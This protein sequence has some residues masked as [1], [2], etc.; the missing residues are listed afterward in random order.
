MLSVSSG[1]SASYLTGAVGAGMESYYTGA[2]TA[3]E[4]PGR[5]VGRG[6]AALGLGGE[7]DAEIMH[8]I[9]ERF[10]DPTDPAFADPA[11][12]QQARV[13]G[14][15]PKQFRTPEQVLAERIRAYPGTP[16]PEQVQQWRIEAERD[17]PKAVM[18]YDLTYSPVKSVTVLHTA[19]ERAAVTARAAG[20]HATAAA[21]QGKV[22][23]IDEAIAAANDTMLAHVA[24]H[25]GYAR[26]G[27]VLGGGRGVAVR[28][29][30]PHGRV[31]RA[32]MRHWRRHHRS[33]TRRPQRL[34]SLV[35]M[36]VITCKR[37]RQILPSRR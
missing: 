3:G 2:V 26:T 30:P 7:V 19:F 28:H 12:R 37:D 13:L 27:R 36:D 5:W 20:D 8:A 11:T 23:D 15:P 10:A 31:A 29:V 25:G 17:T 14:R 34:T 32:A 33:A 35:K 4:P 24:A 16:L 1:H 18:F 6:A 9:Y 21:W 22:R